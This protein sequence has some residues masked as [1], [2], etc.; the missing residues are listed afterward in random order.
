MFYRHKC[1]YPL[2]LSN[3][4]SSIQ[5]CFKKHEAIKKRAYESRICKVEYSTFT[6]LVFS[7]TRGMAHEATIF[8]KKLSSL[9]SDKWKEP[10]ASV[11]GWVP[12]TFLSYTLISNTMHQRKL[13]F[14]RPL[15]IKSAPVDL[16]QSETQFLCYPVTNFRITPTHQWSCRVTQQ[17]TGTNVIW[18]WNKRRRQGLGWAVGTS[19]VCMVEILGFLP[20]ITFISQLCKSLPVEKSHYAKKLFKKLKHARHAQLA[21]KCTVEA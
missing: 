8:C 14:S 20:V 5:S 3:S 11:L 2:I 19:T 16:I 9:L 12:F 21:Q 15:Y 18:S 10:F 7:A 6:S 1:T 17:D 13:V 4:G